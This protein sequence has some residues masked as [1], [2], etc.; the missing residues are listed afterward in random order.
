[1]NVTDITVELSVGASLLLFF[2]L[3]VAF[4]PERKRILSFTPLAFGGALLTFLAVLVA[5]RQ[6][7]EIGGEIG[8][9]VGDLPE[10]LCLNAH[11]AATIYALVL[12]CFCVGA[13]HLV[14]PIVD[15]LTA[16]AVSK[17]LAR[18]AATPLARLQNEVRGAN[19]PHG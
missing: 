6:A 12:G 10:F 15:R 1:M 4:L 18:C 5:Y 16:R 17:A 3:R 7:M 14:F 8:G 13:R 2:L 11:L 19:L 9:R